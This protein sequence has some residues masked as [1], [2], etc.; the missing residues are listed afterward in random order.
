MVGTLTLDFE[1]NL[2][3]LPQILPSLQPILLPS[4]IR[5]IPLAT[6]NTAVKSRS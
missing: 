2:S 6:R 1:G 4:P 5:L 3:R